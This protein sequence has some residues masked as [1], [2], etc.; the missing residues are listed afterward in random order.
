M[1]IFST[2]ITTCDRPEMV[3]DCVSDVL[4]QE[5][6]DDVIVVDDSFTHSAKKVCQSFSSSRV[7]H[8]ETPGRIGP[9]AAR[10]LGVAAARHENVVHLDDDCRIPQPG[11][12]SQAIQ[13]LTAEGV[14]AVAMP[15][16]NILISP[17]VH[18]NSV[19]RGVITPVYAFTA[20]SYAIK[21]KF[22]T[23]VGGYREELFYMGEESDLCIRLM[24]LG[25]IIR[26]GSSS[27]IHHL[28]PA[29]RISRPADHYGRRNEILFEVFNTPLGFLPF[30][31]TKITLKAVRYGM[32][33]Q[34]LGGMLGG[35][36]TGYLDAIKHLRLREPVK[37]STYLEYQRLLR[38]PKSPH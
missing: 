29:G 30:A 2:V 18:F 7:L 5:G 28:Q 1:I 26:V 3:K 20:C 23:D 17:H 37:T 9:S 22:F 13:D 34:R 12:L 6:S 19:P 16:A 27:P 31:I 35:L 21:K 4:S 14:A 36:F 15:Y 25:L 10:N 38:D 24:N 11:T 32:Q 33:T 8:I